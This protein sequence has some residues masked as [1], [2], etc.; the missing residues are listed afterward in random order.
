MKILVILGILCLNDLETLQQNNVRGTWETNSR[1][2]NREVWE[3]LIQL[4]I[5]RSLQ[6]LILETNWSQWK[7]WNHSVHLQR[8]SNSWVEW[9]TS[10]CLHYYFIMLELLKKLSKAESLN[11]RGQITVMQQQQRKI[12]YQIAALTSTTA[13]SQRHGCL[14]RFKQCPSLSLVPNDRAHG[15]IRARQGLYHWANLQPSSSGHTLQSPVFRSPAPKSFL[16]NR[17]TC[18]FRKS[19]CTPL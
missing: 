12:S 7:P 3:R 8:K 10:H 18:F 19:S 14:R 2:L 9:E 4:K 6:V 11:R 15:L 13:N 17:Q 1:L 5:P 16:E